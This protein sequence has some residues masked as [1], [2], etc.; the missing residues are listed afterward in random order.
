MLLLSCGGLGDTVLF[1]H[2][3]PRFRELAEPDETV[4]VLLRS[5]GAKTAFL[6]P[7]EIEKIVVDFGRLRKDRGYRRAICEDLY[8]RN[9][10]L[11]VST[12]FK[13]HPDLDEFLLFTAS[14]AETIAMKARP[15]SK[16]Q[17]RLNTNKSRLTRVFD[18][19]PEHVDKV[20]R[21]CRF[22][23]W[24]TGAVVPPPVANLPQGTVEVKP[25]PFGRR[26]F[27]QPFS[28]VFAKQSPP[29]LYQRL[30][31]GLPDD[32][33]VSIT[34]TDADLDRNPAYKGLLDRQAVRFDNRTFEAIAPD[35][36]T[37]DLVVSVDTA[38]MHL[39]IALGAPT[40]GLA[41]AAYT[42]EIVPYAPQITPP[43]AHFLYR[44]MHC[45]GRLGDCIHPMEGGVFPCI[46]RLD[47]DVVIDTALKLLAGDAVPSVVTVA[48]SG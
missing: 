1:S 15:W 40:L 44:P 10:R 14:A 27:I 46:A 42:G 26:V 38:L 47:R 34:G 36:R 48:E 17:R 9:F 7:S 4:A 32:V 8:R 45:E 28:A 5:D 35:L 22:F 29:E 18:A 33:Q 25:A 20:V 19:G 30:I 6:F 23:D 2:V 39:A 43:N 12:D 41:S 13:R 37:C 11:A 24:L 31:E 21:W 3:L 16:Y